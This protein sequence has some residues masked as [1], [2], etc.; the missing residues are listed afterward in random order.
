[1]PFKQTFGRCLLVSICVLS[2]LGKLAD[3]GPN[4][5]LLL[6]GYSKLFAKAKE[7]G[8]E[9]P[10]KPQVLSIYTNQLIIL[11]AV[12]LLLGSGLVIFNQKLGV[13][14]L[15]GLFIS[16]NVVIHNP[17]IYT[18]DQEFLFH[19]YQALQNFGVLCGF[20]LVCKTNSEEKEKKD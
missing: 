5:K 13:V 2:G 16:F 1:M 15:A 18:K 3:P 8:F 17:W 12:L 10:L 14:I 19:F 4:E 11:T 9:L 6:E 7:I 20:L